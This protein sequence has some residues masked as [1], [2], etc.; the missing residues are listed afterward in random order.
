MKN[1]YFPFFLLICSLSV[2]FGQTY[3]KIQFEV[4]T[5]TKVFSQY[6]STQMIAARVKFGFKSSEWYLGYSQPI[7]TFGEP[8]FYYSRGDTYTF[9]DRFNQNPA[10]CGGL[11]FLLPFEMEKPIIGFGVEY[12]PSASSSSFIIPSPLSFHGFLK[13][14]FKADRFRPYCQFYLARD[15][16]GLP[17]TFGLTYSIPVKKATFEN[18]M[19]WNLRT[20]KNFNPIIFRFD[21]GMGPTFPLDN[22]RNNV[23]FSL[24]MDLMA[25]L[26]SNHYLGMVTFINGSRGGFDKEFSDQYRAN[27]SLKRNES[28][29]LSSFNTTGLYWNISNT[30]EPNMDIFY[31]GG[32]SVYHDGFFYSGENPVAGIFGNFKVRKGVFSN[33]LQLH[34][35]FKEHPLYLA[36]CFAIGINFKSKDDPNLIYK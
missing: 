19:V 3:S 16:E 20:T 36:Y 2:G 14:G 27:P 17:F 29:H 9:N 12:L 24:K 34:I 26:F 22:Y 32:F 7:L 8:Y 4:G 28:T 15:S 13:F 21:L 1:Y 18:N 23:G 31:G 33:S 30:I 6:Q 10:F 35:P 11:D 25:R 5:E